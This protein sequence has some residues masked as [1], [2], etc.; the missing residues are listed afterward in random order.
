MK[1]LILFAFAAIVAVSSFAQT[2]EEVA[3]VTN[4]QGSTK[5]E[6]TENAL[7]SAIEQ[8]FGVFVSAS[9]EI[10]N[11]ELVKDEIATVASGNIQSYKEISSS[12]LSD[13]KYEVMI[14]AVVSVNK[15]VTYARS[16]G[17]TCELAGQKFLMEQRMFELKQENAAKAISHYFDNLAY[18][19]QHTNIWNCEMEVGTP[20]VDEEV[21]DAFKIPIKPR[22]RLNQA[23][24]NEITCRTVKLFRSIGLSN[25]DVKILSERNM[26][27]I[28]ISVVVDINKENIAEVG[29][30]ILTENSIEEV[31]CGV[32]TR[33]Y[34]KGR[35]HEGEVK[36]EKMKFR[37]YASLE[38]SITMAWKNIKKILDSQLY[39]L[40]DNND[41][42]YYLNVSGNS[43]YYPYIGALDKSGYYI[44]KCPSEAIYPAPSKICFSTEFKFMPNC[45][46][47]HSQQKIIVSRE[48]LANIREFKIEMYDFSPM[49]AIYGDKYIKDNQRK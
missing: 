48:K 10:L 33:Y 16:H 34:H 26:K 20:Q 18:Y 25:N 42:I 49:K 46:I 14:R 29:D 11:D 28:D 9:T 40:Y 43:Y 1:K 31:L 17:S 6:A 12:Q 4:G 45:S 30:K 44:P 15:L 36:N 37:V 24:A 5:R 27:T 3:L 32:V 7:R 39:V 35:R 23:A 22:F 19:I 41:N 21:K 47:Y 2:G 13:N 8:A 38:D